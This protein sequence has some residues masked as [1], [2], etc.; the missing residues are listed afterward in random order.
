[1]KKT[2]IKKPMNPFRSG[3]MNHGFF[4]EQLDNVTCECDHF[5]I[6]STNSK[7]ARRLS[8]WF[9]KVAKYLEKKEKERSKY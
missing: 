4:L 2:K 3:K 8:E 1:M 7:E 9:L 5:M 6:Y